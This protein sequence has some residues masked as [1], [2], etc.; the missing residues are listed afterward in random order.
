MK[1]SFCRLIDRIFSDRSLFFLI[2]LVN[3]GGTVYGI[4]YYHLQFM[5]NPPYLW[6]LIS[7][8]PN[9]TLFFAISAILYRR[10]KRIY[11]LEIL[12]ASTLIKYGLWTDF[13]LLYH[14]NH[15][16]SPEWRLLYTGIFIT[17]GGMVLEGLV[18]SPA[19]RK[20]SWRILPVLSWLIFNDYMD[21]FRGIHPYMPERNIQF[22]AEVTFLLSFISILILLTARKVCFRQALR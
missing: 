2:L 20:I 12:A 3:L 14:S 1:F 17:H 15:F 7:D 18:L 9:S 10:G 4:Y 13:V 22:V 5:E 6:I 21:Y 19:I 16:F 11:L 8:S